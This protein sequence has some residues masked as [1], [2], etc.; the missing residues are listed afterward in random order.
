MLPDAPATDCCEGARKAEQRVYLSANA[1]RS[2]PKAPRKAEAAI[3]SLVP[4][5][6]KSFP[7]QGPSMEL[8]GK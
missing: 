4:L 6:S 3:R 1:V 8:D 2:G 5:H 7:F